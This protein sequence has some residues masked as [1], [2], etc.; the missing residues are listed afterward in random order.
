[1][2]KNNIWN[3]YLI[4]GIYVILAFSFFLFG[5]LA[6]VAA[7]PQLIPTITK[8]NPSDPYSLEKN[9]PFE[10]YGITCGKADTPQNKCCLNN[11]AFI[12]EQLTDE[13]QLD[14]LLT[15]IQESSSTNRLSEAEIELISNSLSTYY[16][17]HNTSGQGE[18]NT[19]LS[20]AE[21]LRRGENVSSQD[22]GLLVKYVKAGFTS[23]AV[24]L[25]IE[26]IFNKSSQATAASALTDIDIDIIETAV[27]NHPLQKLFHERID[28]LLARFADPYQEEPL[29]SEEKKRLKE[30]AIQGASYDL[31]R[32]KDVGPAKLMARQMFTPNK[33]IGKSFAKVCIRGIMEFFGGLVDKTGITVALKDTYKQVGFTACE[34]GV[35]SGTPGDPSCV[36]NNPDGLAAICGRYLGGSSEAS[37]CSN[38]IMNKGGFWTGLG[39]IGTD[40]SSFAQSLTGY[41][42]SIGGAFSLLCIFYSSFVLQTSR[43]NPERIKKAKENLRACITGLLLIIFSIFIVRVIGVDLLRIPG[44]N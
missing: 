20:A 15:R 33:C 39:C 18:F 32:N 4:F 36:C 3:R 2:E 40:P 25:N 21:Q 30:W 34:Y 13:D 16:D 12:I 11:D 37:R 6:P 24:R 44:F 14:K 41:G 9:P 31:E 27:E 28:K 22:K 17:E 35:P 5:N 42:L 8:V 19:A 38:C 10:I 1:M 43:G 29:S 26:E 23:R 7:S